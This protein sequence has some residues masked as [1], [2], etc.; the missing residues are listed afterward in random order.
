MKPFVSLR[1]IMNMNIWH[2]S[3]NDCVAFNENGMELK[4]IK[5]MHNSISILL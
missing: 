4:I 1:Y 2:L 5:R 3:L